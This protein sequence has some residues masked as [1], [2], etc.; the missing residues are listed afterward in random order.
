MALDIY[1]CMYQQGQGAKGVMHANGSNNFFYS[2][3][4]YGKRRFVKL[5][6]S[7]DVVFGYDGW[8]ISVVDTNDCLD[9]GCRVF[10][11]GQF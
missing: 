2:I 8:C 10:F 4:N 7:K 1:G 5:W 6:Y 9:I 3:D 11:S